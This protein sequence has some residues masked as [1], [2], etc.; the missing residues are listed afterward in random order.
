[1]FGL[2]II[3]F[4]VSFDFAGVAFCTNLLAKKFVL[5]GDLMISSNPDAAFCYA[6]I[7]ISLWNEYPDFGKLLLAYFFTQCPYLIPFY[8]PKSPEQTNEKYYESLGYHYIDGQVEKQDKFL[9]RMT[10]IFRLYFAIFISRPKREQSKNPHGISN[11]WNFLASILKLEPQLDVTATALHT[12][13]ETVGYEMDTVYGSS[14]K[15]LLKIIDGEFLIKVK[16]IDTG[17]PVSRLER[18]LQEY[19]TK[20]YF[21]KPHGVLPLNFW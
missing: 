13:L 18:L 8:I 14:F 19:K 21:E 12:F 10:G 3:N 5:Q 15:K 4:I 2:L 20:G 11:A 6:T 16:K 9:K 7:I 1:M 17:G